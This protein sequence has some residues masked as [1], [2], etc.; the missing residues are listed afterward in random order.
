MLAAPGGCVQIRRSASVPVRNKVPGLTT[1]FGSLNKASTGTGGEQPGW[2]FY[3]S[4][5]A[6]EGLPVTEFRERPRVLEPFNDGA[7]RVINC[8]QQQ[9]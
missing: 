9:G 1:A 5:T 6:P 7:V 3:P 2:T 8:A 4:T